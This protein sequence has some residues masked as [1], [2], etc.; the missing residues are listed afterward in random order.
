MRGAF[1]V[2]TVFDAFVSLSAVPLGVLLALIA[3]AAIGLAVFAIYVVYSIANDR[4]RR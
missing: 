4:E 1:P 2:N 3:L